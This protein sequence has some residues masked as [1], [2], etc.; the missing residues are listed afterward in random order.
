M[1]VWDE[2]RQKLTLSKIFGKGVEVQM[3]GIAR[4]IAK[5][6]PDSLEKPPAP[7]RN[8]SFARYSSK[9]CDELGVFINLLVTFIQ[10]WEKHRFFIFQK[11]GKSD[12]GKTAAA[13]I[14][15]VK[16]LSVC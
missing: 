16:K 3:F 5:D 9:D 2:R 7:Q 15:L 11:T 14:P 6:P 4:E 13:L 10:K 8:A 12:L 1:F